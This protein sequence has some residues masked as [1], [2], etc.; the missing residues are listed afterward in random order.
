V[1]STNQLTLSVYQISITTS[2]ALPDAL[3][4]QAYS[5][6]LGADGGAVPYK[7]SIA[8]G[9]LPAGLTL[10]SSGAISG[11]P[12]MPGTF[13]FTVKATDAALRAGTKSMTLTVKLDPA[14][15]YITN[16]ALPAGSLSR[17][18]S[19]QLSAVSGP[20]SYVWSLAAGTLPAGLTLSANGLLS[21]TP[22]KA[23]SYSFTVKV[24][25]GAA[26]DTRAYAVPVAA[27]VAVTT[28]SL[29]A[30]NVGTAYSLSLAATGGTKTYTWSIASGTLPAGLTLS[31]GK[32]SG[33][34]TAPGA[35]TL[36]FQVI[37]SAGRVALSNP[38][39]LSV[40]Q[41]SVSYSSG[42]ALPG[43]NTGHPFSVQFVA[44]GGV[45]PY[46]FA[47]TTRSLPSGLSLST[48]GV[49]SGTPTQA[50]TYTIGIKATDAGGRSASKSFTLVVSP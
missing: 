18:Y 8:A 49:L 4:G 39:T 9:T 1:A 30:A 45:A 42:A 3:R 21:G 33:T 43:A 27:A 26:T 38:L 17:P 7:W 34:P 19:A 41:V 32:I 10:A 44:A 22:T 15:P 20:G 47:S 13:T 29:S 35:Q 5:A 28:T 48:S 16:P 36:V 14:V 23:T 11:T 37:D 24:T 12:T 6:S 50:G 46:T 31:A 40:Y 2:S 25:S